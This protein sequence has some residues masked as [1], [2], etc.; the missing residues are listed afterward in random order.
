MASKSAL[1]DEVSGGAANGHA[2]NNSALEKEDHETKKTN[3][4]Y[5]TKSAVLR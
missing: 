1:I 5:R 3:F 4:K 2:N